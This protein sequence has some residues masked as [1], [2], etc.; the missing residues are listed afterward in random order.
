MPSRRGGGQPDKTTFVRDVQIAATPEAAA[1]LDGQS[2]L[3]NRLHNDLMDE[4]GACMAELALIAGYGLA[5]DPVVRAMAVR[6]APRAPVRTAA[7]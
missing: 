5:D 2:K 6:P 1:M 3:C 4:V 7:M